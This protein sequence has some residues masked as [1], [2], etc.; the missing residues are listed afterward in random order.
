MSST[1]EQYR[2]EELS[3][4]NVYV[5]KVDESTDS[6]QSSYILGV[7]ATKG[8]CHQGSRPGKY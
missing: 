2:Q 3:R 6:D 4:H 7:Y 1:L 8:V 5:V